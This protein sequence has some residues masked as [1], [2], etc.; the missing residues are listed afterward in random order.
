MGFGPSSCFLDFFF[1]FFKY[2]NGVTSLRKINYGTTNNMYYWKW[3]LFFINLYQANLLVLSKSIRVIIN[4]SNLWQENNDSQ[5]FVLQWRRF[6]VFL[7]IH[8]LP[9]VMSEMNISI[10]P[11]TSKN[12]FFFWV[13]DGKITYKSLN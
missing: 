7:S 9:N 12:F 3:C 13:R 10:A 11:R 6:L 8:C 2:R 4:K 1:N 5:C